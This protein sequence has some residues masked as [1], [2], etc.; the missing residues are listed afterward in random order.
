MAMNGAHS[1]KWRPREGTE[2]VSAPF[3]IAPAPADEAERL[4]ALAAYS[5]LD[6]APEAEFD[7]IVRRAAN[8]AGTPIALI[9]LVDGKRQ[10]FKARVGLDADETPREAAFCAHAIL[11]DEVFVVPDTTR[12]PRFRGNPLVIGAPRVGAYAGAPLITPGGRRIGTLCV[13]DHGPRLFSRR[14]IAGLKTLAASAM[15]GLEQRRQQAAA[16][17]VWGETP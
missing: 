10:W 2:P 6:T 8:L 9:S 4:A 15:A 13:I 5:V 12:D 16:T 7:E 17:H 11:S 3:A 14:T 1:G